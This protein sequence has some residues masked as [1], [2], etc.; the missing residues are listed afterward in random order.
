VELRE[1]LASANAN[2]G[3]RALAD[4]FTKVVGGFD[5]S[6]DRGVLR[7]RFSQEL[8]TLVAARDIQIIDT[9]APPREG[10]ESIYFSVPANG[11][12]SAVL[13]ATFERDHHLTDVEFR[14]LQMAASLAAVVLEL[15]RAGG[16]S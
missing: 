16:H 9:P 14:C 3:P 4:L 15:E 7:A 5:Q 8:R 11:R 2:S 12:S 10:T 6:D 1:S 13:Q